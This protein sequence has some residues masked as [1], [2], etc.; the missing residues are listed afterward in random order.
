LKIDLPN[1]FLLSVAQS[2]VGQ[3]SIATLGQYWIAINM[4]MA[5]RCRMQQASA[6]GCPDQAARFRGGVLTVIAA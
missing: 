2:W 1:L 3:N 4:R 6:T 5:L